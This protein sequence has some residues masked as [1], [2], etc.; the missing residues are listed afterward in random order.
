MD[1]NG[2]W[3]SCPLPVSDEREQIGEDVEVSI[4]KPQQF[5]E[6]IKLS[7]ICPEYKVYTDELDLE[8]HKE[9]RDYLKATSSL[10]TSTS[11]RTDLSCYGVSESFLRER[12]PTTVFP[13]E[14]DSEE[15]AELEV[16]SRLIDVQEVNEK[17]EVFTS[18]TDNSQESEQKD[19]AEVIKMQSEEVR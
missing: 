16:I 6:V 9:F 10:E 18:R 5:K 1:I 14:S 15:E 19:W 7:R 8:D 3:E 4:I 12:A 13:T 11:V 17:T 2:N